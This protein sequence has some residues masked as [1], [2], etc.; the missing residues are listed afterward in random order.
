MQLGLFTSDCTASQKETKDGSLYLSRIH[1][2]NHEQLSLC[3]L[4]LITAAECWCQAKD[5][6]RFHISEVL[7]LIDQQELRLGQAEQSIRS[8][9]Y[10]ILRFDSR[11]LT[12]SVSDRLLCAERSE[13]L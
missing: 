13:S 4:I 8:Q 9:A 1:K 12:D 2:S 7:G 3:R 5:A 10:L 11:D 6:V